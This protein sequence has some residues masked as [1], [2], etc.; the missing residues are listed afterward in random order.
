MIDFTGRVAIVTGGGRGLGRSYAL[1]LARRGAAVIVN[2]PGVDPRGQGGD[3]SV[4]ESV[5]AEITNAG[6]KAKADRHSVATTAGAEAIVAAAVDSYGRLDIVVNNAGVL[7]T[8]LLTDLKPEEVDAH[9]D[10]HVKGSTY[11][12]KAAFE[13]MKGQRYGRIVFVGSMAGM[14]G[15]TGLAAYGTAKG[16]IF[17]L[18]N[19]VANEGA[20]HGIFANVVMPVGTT[21]MGNAWT[22]E[23][24]VKAGL[25][26]I[27]PFSDEDIADADH[28]VPA[29]AV[30]YLASETCT[31]THHVFSTA[32][33]RIAR[34]FV[35]VTSGWRKAN[36]TS[37]DDIGAHLAEI[38]DRSEYAIPMTASEENELA[39]TP[40]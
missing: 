30:T 21:R 18:A 14:F 28:S 17:G 22:A 35:G 33:G 23:K 1:E 9:L 20:P 34:V 11:V 8:N 32:G 10:V 6:G 24:R 19:V 39:Q 15:M 29:A 38:V 7:L 4:A 37:A 12:T 31:L 25:P 27:D 5:A 16:A 13:V 26:P 3:D 40:R 36:G 2:D